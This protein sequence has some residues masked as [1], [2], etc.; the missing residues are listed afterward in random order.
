M[1]LPHGR[2]FGLSLKEGGREG[3]KKRS[4]VSLG[5]EGKG[6]KGE[7]GQAQ[8]QSHRKGQESQPDNRERNGP[9]DGDGGKTSLLSDPPVLL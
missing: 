1:P 8:G 3:R 5:W 9:G 7:K 6:E 2:A 4:H